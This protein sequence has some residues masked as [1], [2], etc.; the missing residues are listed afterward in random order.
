MNMRFRIIVPFVV[1]SFVGVVLLL[2]LHP[3]ALPVHAAVAS[4]TLGGGALGTLLFLAQR[5]FGRPRGSTIGLVPVAILGVLAAA[6]ELLWRRV[7]L[8]S[9]LPLGIPAAIGFSTL[10][11]ALLHRRPVFHLATGATFGAAYVVTGQLSAPIAAHWAYNVGIAMS[12]VTARRT[13]TV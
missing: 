10:G 5:G 2:V 1:P 7:V 6:E 8:A 12:V 9:L 11:F 13:R 3:P 4:A